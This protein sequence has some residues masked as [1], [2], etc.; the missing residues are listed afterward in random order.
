MN[1]EGKPFGNQGFNQQQQNQ[2]QVQIKNKFGE[3]KNLF[4]SGNVDYNKLYSL[5]EEIA[6]NLEINST[7]IRKFYNHVKKLELDKDVDITRNLN[8]FV[9][10]L[11]YDVGREGKPFLK[12]FASG[13]KEVVDVV[14][15]KKGD[16]LIKHYKY[17]V[18]FFESL[19]AYHKFYKG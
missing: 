13:M 19:V 15:Q 2:N 9:A 6:K 17:F 16:E 10:M 11:M 14:K 4:V 12:D 3:V 5:S 1:G 7:K 18:D 8:K